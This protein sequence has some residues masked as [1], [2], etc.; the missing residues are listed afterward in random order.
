M[1]RLKTLFFKQMIAMFDKDGSNT[2]NV[3]EFCELWRFL[4]QWRQ[5]FQQFDRDRSGNISKRELATA[6]E[7]MGY[8]FFRRNI[9]YIFQYIFYIPISLSLDNFFRFSPFFV[10]MLFVKFD[11]NRR[12]HLEFDGFVH[13]CLIIQRLTSNFAKFDSNR[14]GNAVFNY[15]QF[16]EIAFSI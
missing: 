2:I 12:N 3:N 8:R 4:G 9:F 15:E 5:T 7:Q 1:A 14:N 13:A 6:L 16:L 10:D 11:Y